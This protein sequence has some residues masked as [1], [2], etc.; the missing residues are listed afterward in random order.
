MK[1]RELRHIIKQLLLEDP[2]TI[3]PIVDFREYDALAFGYFD[4]KMYMGLESDDWHYK[5]MDKY[6]LDYPSYSERQ[7]AGKEARDYLDFPGRLWYN[8]RYISFW[9]YPKNM[10]QL[11]RIINDINE[12][13]KSRGLPIIDSTWML[14][15]GEYD[16]DIRSIVIPIMQYKGSNAVV[17][18]SKQHILSPL[19]KTQS[20]VPDTTGSKRKYADQLPDETVA[21]YKH[22]T[23]TSESNIS[24]IKQL[25]KEIVMEEISKYENKYPLITQTV[26]TD[27]I[28]E[29][30]ELVDAFVEEHNR[31]N[32]STVIR[33][34]NDSFNYITWF[35]RA[36]NLLSTGWYAVALQFNVAWSEKHNEFKLELQFE[37]KP[38]EEWGNGMRSMPLD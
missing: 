2:D 38:T 11:K 14:D 32:A 34:F 26:N 18:T 37:H 7:A 1:R 15:T 6:G 5:M 8:N 20:P 22:R 21:Q 28:V 24:K 10:S 4:G 19:E 27:D 17:D 23:S 35:K 30:E 9:H 16:D 31:N 33:I 13:L 25:I 29:L 36:N 3:E 12:I